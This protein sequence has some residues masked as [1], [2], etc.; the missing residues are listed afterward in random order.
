MRLYGRPVFPDGL[1]FFPDRAHFFPDGIQMHLYGR[2]VFPDGAHFFPDGERFF[3]DGAHFF[4]DGAHFF[5]DTAHFFPD[6]VVVSKLRRKLTTDQHRS[7]RIFKISVKSALIRC[8]LR[9]DCGVRVHD[10]EKILAGRQHH[11]KIP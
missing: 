4:P 6:G 11:V 5:P 2:S 7:A 10:A 1:H 9:C 8:C 3:P